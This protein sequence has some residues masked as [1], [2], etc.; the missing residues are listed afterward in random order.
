[1]IK[2]KNQNSEKKWEGEGH[3]LPD[4]LC[5]TTHGFEAVKIILPDSSFVS[6]NFS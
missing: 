2:I 4:P 6:A 1:M 3:G 5:C